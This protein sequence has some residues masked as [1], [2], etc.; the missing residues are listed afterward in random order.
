MMNSLKGFLDKCKKIKHFPVLIAVAVGLVVCVIYFSV[1]LPTKN[2]T[3]LPETTETATSAMEYVDNLENRLNNV[4]SKIS[5]VQSV[6]T[7]ITLESGFSY[8]YATDTETKTTTSG[9]QEITITTIKLIWD[10]DKPV[11]V[12]EIYPVI[13]GVVV[14]AKGAENFSVKMDI[15]DAVETI[16][17]IDRNSITILS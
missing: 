1:F 5:G 3:K 7:L 14:V 8:Q 11:V 16:L 12:K 13:K 6:N 15:M 9:G 10:E 17:Q 4:L 2:D